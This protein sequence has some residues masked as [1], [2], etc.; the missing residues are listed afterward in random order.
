[1]STEG[2]KEGDVAVS[3]PTGDDDLED[4]H[5]PDWERAAR[6]ALSSERIEE[7]DE[8]SLQ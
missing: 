6:K 7:V 3:P 8:T 2:G 5:N 4:T 1:M